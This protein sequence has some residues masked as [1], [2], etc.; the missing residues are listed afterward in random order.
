MIKLKDILS[1]SANYNPKDF[2]TVNTTY[3]W[4][5]DAYLKKKIGD[6]ADYPKVK[7]ELTTLKNAMSIAWK[8]SP[9]I[10][11]NVK[12]EDFFRLK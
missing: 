9:L 12:P 7:K 1:E 5:E 4:L 3:E 8:Y 10:D 6:P 2:G 11:G